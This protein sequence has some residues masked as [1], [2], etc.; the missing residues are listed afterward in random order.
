MLHS[1]LQGKK[2]YVFFFISSVWF[3]SGGGNLMGGNFL[4]GGG[5]VS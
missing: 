2:I 5:E 1:F 3:A 4:R